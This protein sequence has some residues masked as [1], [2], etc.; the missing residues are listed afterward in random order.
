ME[1]PI[2]YVCASRDHGIIVVCFSTPF[3]RLDETSFE[4][5]ANFESVSSRH[6]LV[7]SF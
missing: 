7:L 1:E 6:Y 2:R 4:T 3:D 5:P